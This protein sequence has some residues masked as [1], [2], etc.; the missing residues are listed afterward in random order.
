MGLYINPIHCQPLLF[1]L[2]TWSLFLCY[3]VNLM[4]SWLV[5]IVVPI[6]VVCSSPCIFLSQYYWS[7]YSTELVNCPRSMNLPPIILAIQCT[8]ISIAITICAYT[9]GLVSFVSFR[10]SFPICCIICMTLRSLTILHATTTNPI[11]KPKNVVIQKNSKLLI[12]YPPI[13]LLLLLQVLVLNKNVPL[14]FFLSISFILLI[15]IILC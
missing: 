6:I 2:F 4:V 5:L 1:R 9:S 7:M 11:N 14:L 8:K 13:S 15:N 10:S 3:C 12:T